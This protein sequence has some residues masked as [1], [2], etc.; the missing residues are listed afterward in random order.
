MVT[1]APKGK[2]KTAA[3]PGSTGAPRSCEK[4]KIMVIGG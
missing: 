1:L 2:V 3:M 4:R